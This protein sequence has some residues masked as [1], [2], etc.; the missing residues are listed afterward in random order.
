MVEVVFRH[1]GLV[2]T[3]ES[4]VLQP[5][6]VSVLDEAR[7]LVPALQSPTALQVVTPRLYVRRRTN[8]GIL[9]PRSKQLT[10]N[11]FSRK[12]AFRSVLLPLLEKIVWFPIRSV[13]AQ[14]ITNVCYVLQV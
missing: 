13:L 4:T 14:C 11:D 10:Q 5:F 1:L 2:G 8:P 3:R 9:G 6:R 7:E 12:A